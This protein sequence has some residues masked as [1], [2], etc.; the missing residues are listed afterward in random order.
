VCVSLP[1]SPSGGKETGTA[2]EGWY[3]FLLKKM[4]VHAV[5]G[6]ISVCVLEFVLPP[7][8][9]LEYPR[10]CPVPA[11]RAVHQTC[12]RLLKANGEMEREARA[13]DWFVFYWHWCMC[14]VTIARETHV[15]C[16]GEMRVEGVIRGHLPEQPSTV[17]L[18]A[19][20]ATPVCRNRVQETREPA[21]CTLVFLGMQGLGLWAEERHVPSMRL[22]PDTRETCTVQD[23][24]KTQKEHG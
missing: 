19:G 24:A 17:A 13:S 14:C 11:G 20:R 1:L 6:V 9:P 7:P 2:L 8:P 12:D 16:K 21:A 22:R 23:P 3:S 18:H 10:K 4:R 5:S 15:A